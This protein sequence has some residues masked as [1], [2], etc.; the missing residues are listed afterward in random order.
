MKIDSLPSIN[1]T[2]EAVILA[3][4]EFP[5]HAV[6]YSILS[7]STYVVCCDGAIDAL[8]QTSILPQAIVGDCDSMSPQNKEKY[9]HI[10]HQVKEQE[11]NDL[12]K[13]VRFCVENE[14]KNI[15]ILGATGKREDHAI[16]NISLLTEYIDHLDNV[17]MI[18]N[19]GVFNAISGDTQ[20]E[21]FD[22]QQVS[23]FCIT[24]TEITSEGL[25]YPIEKRIFTSWWQATLNES[26]SNQFVIKTSNKIIVFRA[27]Q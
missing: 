12:T 21:S 24:P 15:V 3:N 14:I 4:G 19:Y 27:F 2:V 1:T 7:N 6:P 16:A 20:F 22:G 10:I 25:K 18:T 26:I 13:S 17:S 11:T 9:K 23:L 8:A 5:T